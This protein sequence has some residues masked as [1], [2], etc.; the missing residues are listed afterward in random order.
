M[1]VIEN[2]IKNFFNGL[3]N[4][5]KVGI[6]NNAKK[7]AASKVGSISVPDISST[8]TTKTANVITVGDILGIGEKALAL[9]PAD[10]NNAL[11][12]AKNNA[13]IM[14]T[15]AAF[16]IGPLNTVFA[17]YKT[18]TNLINTYQKIKPT[19]DMVSD[20]VSVIL[21]NYAR[22][23]VII[24]NIV[25]DI[26]KGIAGEIPG[27]MEAIKKAFLEMPVFT[28]YLTPYQ[29]RLLNSL[30]E[31]EKINLEQ[32]VTDTMAEYNPISAITG[33]NTNEMRKLL[34][35][36][37][38]PDYT[39]E[40][41]YYSIY[42]N[43]TYGIGYKAENVI[44]NACADLTE[45]A[46]AMSDIEDDFSTVVNDDFFMYLG[47]DI[48]KLGTEMIV[49]GINAI[50]LRDPLTDNL[51]E[52]NQVVKSFNDA[53]KTTK[54][55]D[56]YAIVINL[57]KET[58]DLRGDIW[59]LMYAK[60]ENVFTRGNN[61]N[62]D[63]IFS[64]AFIKIIKEKLK[65]GMEKFINYNLYNLA[66]A[67]ITRHKEEWLDSV[68]SKISNSV[69]EH[70]YYN[71]LSDNYDD[72]INTKFD[73]LYSAIDTD[74]NDYLDTNEGTIEGIQ[75]TVS[76]TISGTTIALNATL[77][78]DFDASVK[79]SLD[80]FR[81]YYYYDTKFIIQDELMPIYSVEIPTYVDKQQFI[82]VVR[83]LM[84][85]VKE[86]FVNKLDKLLLSDEFYPCKQCKN[87]SLIITDLENY[88]TSEITRRKSIINYNMLNLTGETEEEMLISFD[89]LLEL[90]KRNF[91]TD[92]K[93][94]SILS[95]Q[96]ELL[97]KH[98]Y[99]V[100]VIE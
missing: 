24:Q 54:T 50:D 9:S 10:F 45:F 2:T 38:T 8:I 91:I 46:T 80:L 37:I 44:I 41:F 79:Y 62:L 57:F 63:Y 71:N 39:D 61:V 27:A 85:D 52:L 29:M 56:L 19:I 82:N 25:S 15:Q 99:E 95:K 65:E 13:L 36:G 5:A 67:Y 59:D 78:E 58:N 94:I 49:P 23:P 1:G 92:Y 76:S 83:F 53:L 87:Y 14:A 72:D 88:Y 30:V 90:S 74:V 3:V 96:K 34:N 51:G 97:K 75:S 31:N 42:D 70:T 35:S 20:I 11:S 81:N 60:A 73:N 64:N 18:V 77:K 26:M 32:I 93:F 66:A 12:K 33:Y 47:K 89:A 98:I 28:L 4:G 69:V 86:Y 40:N 100:L 48:V 6:E 21:F 43:V 68:K 16:L 22:L 17:V 55:A 7:Q 84:S